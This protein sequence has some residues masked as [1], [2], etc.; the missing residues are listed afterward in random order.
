MSTLEAIDLRVKGGKFR[1][2]VSTACFRGVRV[3][4]RTLWRCYWPAWRR[5]AGDSW[6]CLQEPAENTMSGFA[7]TTS[8][9]RGAGVPRGED[10]APYAPSRA[11]RL[12]S[13]LRGGG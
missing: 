7:S 1:V 8:I 5:L 11:G 3:L 6:Q 9:P 2:D 12:M 4:Y 13:Y 10:Y